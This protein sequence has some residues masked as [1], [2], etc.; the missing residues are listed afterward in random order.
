MTS[1]HFEYCRFEV[2]GQVAIMTLNRPQ[3]LNALH[4]GAHAEL[5]RAFD[6]YAANPDLRVCIVTG[7]G[8][9]AFCVGSDL[10]ALACTGGYPMPD[11]GFG[12]IT[13]RFDLFKPV[14]AAVN[15]L[16]LGGGM[17]ILA[18][19]DIAVAVEHARFGLPEPRV[20]LAALGGGLLQRLPRQIGFKH[21][22]ALVL[23]GSQISSQQALNMGLINEVVASPEYLM[24]RARAIAA[25]I[26]AG[27]PLA[28]EASKQVMMQSMAIADLAQAMQ[29]EY[30]LAQRMLASE[31]AREGPLAF[32]QK[33]A[34]RWCG[35]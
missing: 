12:G 8:Q 20:G 28:I 24:P 16:C 14:I 3:V 23:T 6:Q 7:E 19:C 2:D 34:P 11:T 35:K 4:G 31:D 1:R 5:A 29:K 27:A 18:A 13:H 10:K 30:P 15:G 26:V 25:E 22:M 21:A 32:A 9:R 33:R 17:E